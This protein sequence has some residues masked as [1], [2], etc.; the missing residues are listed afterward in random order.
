MTNAEA[1]KK[2]RSLFMERTALAVQI[3]QAERAG[4]PR[5]ASVQRYD[6]L[7]GTNDPLSAAMQLLD[8]LERLDARLQQESKALLPQIQSLLAQIDDFKLLVII[9]RYYLFAETDEQIAD[10]LHLNDRYICKKRNAFIRQQ[11]RPAPMVR[12]PSAH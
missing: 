11:D 10:V 3:H 12:T 7:P 2:Y 6:A 5:G 1:L 8:G 4:H 9:Q